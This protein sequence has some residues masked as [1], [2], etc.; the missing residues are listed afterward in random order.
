VITPFPMAAIPTKKDIRVQ[1]KDFFSRYNTNLHRRNFNAQPL[2]PLGA[3]AVNPY[4]YGAPAAFAAPPP[5]MGASPYGLASPYGFGAPAPFAAAPTYLAPP[6]AG[7]AF[8]APPPFYPATFAGTPVTAPTYV[9]PPLG[10]PRPFGPPA[11]GA[12]GAG[13]APLGGMPPGPYSGGMVNGHPVIVIP[14]PIP[15]SR[16]PPPCNTCNTCETVDIGCGPCGSGGNN[17]NTTTTYSSF[18]NNT[19]G[20]SP[21]SYF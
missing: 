9:A 12:Y 18:G 10:G 16:P 1:E 4:A 15:F 17:F 2:Q 19:F 6:M 7:P 14:R 5:Y 13:M 11:Y 8:G 20:G 21:G 3:P